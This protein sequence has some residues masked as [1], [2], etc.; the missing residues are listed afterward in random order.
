MKKSLKKLQI[1]KEVVSN[2]HAQKVTGGSIFNTVTE[3]KTGE[4]PT[5]LF[6]HT[7]ALVCG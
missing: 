1:N 2:F 5:D 3:C 7:G 6:C 4:P